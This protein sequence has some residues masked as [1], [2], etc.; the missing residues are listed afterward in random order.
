MDEP[1]TLD[2][3]AVGSIADELGRL[4]GRATELAATIELAASAAE[5]SRSSVPFV[6]ELAD[7][8]DAL[9]RLL[10]ATLE[11]IEIADR[12]GSMVTGERWFVSMRA[13][14]AD[15][16]RILWTGLTD[17]VGATGLDAGGFSLASALVAIDRSQ[18][19]RTAIPPGCR[20][21]GP[22]AYYTGGGAVR[23]PD[24]RLY[25]IVVPHVQRGDEHYTIDA[26]IPHGVPTAAS[27]DGQDAG[28]IVVGY[29]TGVEQLH[30]DVSATW[31]ALLAAAFATGLRTTGSVDDRHLAAIE[32][33]LG[34]RPTF[35]GSASAS[36]SAS[37]GVE[38]TTGQEVQPH[39]GP[40]VDGRVGGRTADGR[41]RT[42]P[43][44]TPPASSSTIAHANRHLNAATLVVNGLQGVQ[45]ALSANDTDH[46]AYEVIL[47]EHPD[48]RRRARVQTFHLEPR[49]DGVLLAGWHL[50]VDDDGAL[51]QSPVKYQTPPD[52]DEQADDGNHGPDDDPQNRDDD[53][54]ERP[55]AV[56]GLDHDYAPPVPNPAFSAG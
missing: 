35:V 37:G 11:R 54:S 20:S 40:V 3:A 23:G 46:R 21:F 55:V 27:L 22:D 29:R 30:A 51:R 33:R 17:D 41:P 7:E 36:A 47:E 34:S 42:K 52:G 8:L 38:V 13:D 12:L 19:L 1:L 18:W 53:G 6:G 49:A 24:G 2:T 9:R 48:G 26:D 4:A 25:P 39:T 32:I 44:P 14:W 31:Q 15:A 28:W 56:N 43:L 10:H 16:E 50:F 5:L 45:V